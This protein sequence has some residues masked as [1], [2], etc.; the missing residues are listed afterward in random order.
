MRGNGPFSSRERPL[1]TASAD[2]TPS[3]SS[4]SISGPGGTALVVHIERINA[5][6]HV[7]SRA[8][9]QSKHQRLNALTMKQFPFS[10]FVVSGSIAISC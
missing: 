3:M 4:D 10:F 7:F 1:A 6:G 8:L 5:G 2:S 9:P